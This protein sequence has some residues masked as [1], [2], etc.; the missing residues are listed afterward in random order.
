MRAMAIKNLVLCCEEERRKERE[1][2]PR[3]G[4]GAPVLCSTTNEKKGHNNEHSLSLTVEVNLQNIVDEHLHKVADMIK[5]VAH[6]L[7]N[8]LTKHFILV[9]NF[10]IFDR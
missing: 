8:F 6:I 7:N 5:R 2:G 3:K 10:A 1:K 4:R 9:S